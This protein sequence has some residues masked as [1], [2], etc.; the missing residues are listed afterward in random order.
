MP[1]W[2]TRKSSPLKW[3]TATQT[4]GTDWAFPSLFILR[5][6]CYAV[7][8]SALLFLKTF[9]SDFGSWQPLFSWVT[10]ASALPLTSAPVSRE[11]LRLLSPCDCKHLCLF[12][13]PMDDSLPGPSVHGI[14]QVRVLQWVAVSSSRD[15]S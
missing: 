5:G 15:S 10:M 2:E 4:V 6:F 12:C 13:Y 14:L 3:H 1:S 8:L 11:G 7:C 9:Y